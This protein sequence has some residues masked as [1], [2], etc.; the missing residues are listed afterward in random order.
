M[1]NIHLNQRYF[2]VIGCFLAFLILGVSFRK[3]ADASIKALPNLIGNSFQTYNHPSPLEE[4]RK[5]SKFFC[6]DVH[7]VTITGVSN[8]YKMVN[9]KNLSLALFDKADIVSNSIK[10]NGW[11]MNEINGI[12]TKLDQ[13]RASGLNPTFLDIG[14]NVGW[15][16][17]QAASHGYRTISFD[18]MR[19]NGT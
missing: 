16:S 17:I 13:A 18:A 11:E 3:T 19:V 5:Y 9:G 15:F 6:S 4:Q 14:S 1:Q 2:V 10:G 7:P 8:Y 12:L